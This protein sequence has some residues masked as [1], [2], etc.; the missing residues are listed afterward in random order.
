MGICLRKAATVTLASLL[1]GGMLAGCSGDDSTDPASTPGAATPGSTAASSGTPAAN[2]IT[3]SYWGNLNENA[4]AVVTNLN[5]VEMYKELEQRTGV[6]VD[7]KHPSAGNATEAFGLL[8]ASRDLTDV[9]EYHWTGYPGGPSKAIEDEIIIPLQDLIQEHAPN[10]QK[11]LDDYPEVKKQI[12]TDDGM[13][14]A[15]PSLSLHEIKVFGGMLVRKDWLDDL[16]L[17]EPETIDDWENMLRAFKE[18]KGASNPLTLLKSHLSGTNSGFIGAF[19]VNNDFF[20]DNGTVKY[21]PYD[22]A[23]KGFLELF[24]KW[25]EEGLLDPDFVTNDTS[26]VDSKITNGQSGATFGW[27][28]GT[29][30]KYLAAFEANNNQDANMVMTQ[31]PVLEKGTEPV[32]IPRDFEFNLYGAAAITTA[33]QHPVETVKWL[34]YLYSDEGHLLKN[35]GIEGLTYNMV[36]GY[37]TYTD[38]ILKNPDGLNV[39][40]ATAKYFRAN[41]PSPGLGDKRYLEQYYAYPQQKEALS[42]L[43]QYG[44]NAVDVL[45][46]PATNT[47]DEAQELSVI[48]GEINTYRDEMIYKFILGAESLDNFD[49]FT[50]QLKAMRIEEAIALKQAALDRYNAK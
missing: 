34:D 45:F 42:L 30:G 47:P 24:N 36:D 18:Q 2:P 23:F 22:P 16:G 8:V 5:Q 49:K 50:Q 32:F 37:P 13:I 17:A 27:I 33:N 15:F 48:M 7:F 39:A 40:Q 14:Y 6:K 20:V 10:L 9:I 29:L 44:D 11:V 38:L 25:Y 43:A 28:G 35:F 19:G 41:Y 46:P 31:Y 4:A 3:I 12:T 26:I 1:A 21:G